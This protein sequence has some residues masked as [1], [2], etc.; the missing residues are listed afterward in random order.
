MDELIQIPSPT[1]QSALCESL[2]STF[3]AHLSVTFIEH[4]RKRSD[5]RQS[6]L[7]MH[8]AFATRL[9]SCLSPKLEYMS[10]SPFPPPLPGEG[11]VR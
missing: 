8:L 6:L 2:R 7:I 1:W 9:A 3:T 5:V 10:V 4:L 11:G